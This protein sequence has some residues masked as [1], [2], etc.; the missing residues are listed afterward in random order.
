MTIP[1]SHTLRSCVIP[2]IWVFAISLIVGLNQEMSK[3]GFLPAWLQIQHLDTG[4]VNLHT[5]SIL[6]EN[7][8]TFCAD[9]GPMTSCALSHTGYRG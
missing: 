6:S 1:T 4:A 8:S 9:H 7:F 2:S 3:Q 5:F